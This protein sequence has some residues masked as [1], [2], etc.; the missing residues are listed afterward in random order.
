MPL[1]KAKR[2]GT[3]APPSFYP[4]KSN[5]KS[6]KQ[7]GTEKQRGRFFLPTNKRGIA[8]AIL[9]HGVSPHGKH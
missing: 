1:D 3:L 6:K 2:I 5:G 9:N 8:K 7:R 4:S